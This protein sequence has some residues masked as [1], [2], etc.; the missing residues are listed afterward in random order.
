[1]PAYR[2]F[3]F[4]EHEVWVSPTGIRRLFRFLP[5]FNGTY[6][7]H[8]I[9][10]KNLTKQQHKILYKWLLVRWDGKNV[11]EVD[12]GMDIFP[13]RPLKTSRHEIN[14]P[15]LAISG[16]HQIHVELGS[17]QTLKRTKKKIWVP[18]M[19]K[20]VVATFGILE[21]DK[22]GF[23]ILITMGSL[24]LGIF[25]TLLAEWLVGRF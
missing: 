5:Y 14:L 8:V 15:Y 3:K 9:N 22:W 7:S 11:H 24:I 21:R 6:V 1:M 17:Y 25:L 2:K 16:E 10:V 13:C 4:G 20:S 23:Y 18:I 19:P 12:E